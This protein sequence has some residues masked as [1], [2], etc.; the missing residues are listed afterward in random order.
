MEIQAIVKSPVQTGPQTSQQFNGG[1]AA[2]SGAS[3]KT[4]QS[5][6]ANVVTVTPEA[7][8][9]QAERRQDKLGKPQDETVGAQQVIE[10]LRL[11]SRRTQLEFNTELNTVFV[12]I[13][14]TRTDEVVETIPPEELVRQ[15]KASVEPPSVGTETP[16]GGVIDRS[17]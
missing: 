10:S 16:G 12:Q 13:I 9:T 8:G 6:P 11:T 1:S 2:E 15:L 3:A 14:D 5:N 17:I 4:I 7:A